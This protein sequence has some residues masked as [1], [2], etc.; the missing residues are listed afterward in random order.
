MRPSAALL[1]LLLPALSSARDL[2]VEVPAAPRVQVQNVPALQLP[3]APQALSGPSLRAPVKADVQTAQVLPAALPALPAAAVPAARS[4]QAF[5]AAAA[6]E[7]KQ[8]ESGGETGWL[9]GAK[10]FDKALSDDSA[11]EAAVQRSDAAG[12]KDRGAAAADAALAMLT[13]QGVKA[14]RRTYTSFGRTY[15]GV[16]VAAVPGASELND[17]AVDLDKQLGATV[18]YVPARTSDSTAAYDAKANSLLVAGFDRPDFFLALLHEAR[19]AWYS[20]QLRR[21]VVRLFHLQALARRGLKLA[22][23]AQVYASY[24]SFEELSTYPKT[25]KHMAA[26]IARATGEKCAYLEGKARSRAYHMMDILRTAERLGRLLDR[27]ELRRMSKKEVEA[28]AFPSIPGVDW[29][30][31]DLGPSSFYLPVLERETKLLGFTRRGGSKAEAKRHLELRQRLIAQLIERMVQP[32]IDYT[33][34]ANAGDWAKASKKAD[35]LIRASK[36]AEDAWLA[37]VTQVTKAP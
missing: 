2:G 7:S 1:G 27:A 15:E 25:L 23:K 35:A 19:H 4:A 37:A 20:A 13:A 9:D 29:F 6:D 30:E 24:L 21:G 10:L 31:A 14:E 8:A 36:D 34:A 18:D 11:L 17:L 32:A 12:W 5:T 3:V 28:S 33:E 26:E 22:P 16:R